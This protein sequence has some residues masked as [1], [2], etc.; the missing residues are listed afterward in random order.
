M[1]AYRVIRSRRRTLALEITKDCEVI[2]RSPLFITSEEIDCFVAKHRRWLEAHLDRRRRA[3]TLTPSVQTPEE[4]AALKAKARARIL[5][6]VAYYAERTGLVPS[7]VK[8][9]SARTRYGSCNGKNGLCFSCYLADVPETALDLVVVHELV[10][11]R[12][13]NH[14]PGFYALLERIL[15]DWKARKALLSGRSE[16]I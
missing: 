9:T 14:G 1:E 6:R 7:G 5:P 11:I 10:H 4:Q 16:S 8:I 12:V 2:V 13:K 3:A 15:P